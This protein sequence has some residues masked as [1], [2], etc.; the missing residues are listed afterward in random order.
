MASAEAYIPSHGAAALSPRALALALTPV[1][2]A[3]LEAAGLLGQRLAP[4]IPFGRPIDPAIAAAAD[5][6]CTI[7]N[8][9]RGT[10]RS[11]AAKH[12]VIYC[13]LI[14]ALGRRRSQHST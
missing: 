14:S 2:R 12:G 10:A 13:S 11:I 5:E 9:R 4:V 1:E 3:R 7:V 6:Y 8:P